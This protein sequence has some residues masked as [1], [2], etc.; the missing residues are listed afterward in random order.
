MKTMSEVIGERLKELRTKRNLSQAQLSKLCGW[1][2]ASRVGN[3]ESGSRNIGADDA[4]V[5]ARALGVTP[6]EL[7]FGEQGDP[8]NWLNDRQ[9][10]VLLLFDQLPEAEQDRM[11]DLFQLRLR[12]L[13][14]YV[15]K[16]L[17][18]RYKLADE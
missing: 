18:G 14:D 4:V 13:D 3:Y 2:T 11:I 12:E 16:Y 17:R 10:A 8:A 7:L 9:R 1:A 15:E 6:S 5:L